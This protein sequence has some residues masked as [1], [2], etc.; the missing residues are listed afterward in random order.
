DKKVSAYPRLQAGVERTGGTQASR[1]PNGYVW[2]K[3]IPGVDKF[4][5]EGHEVVEKEVS[6]HGNGAHVY[7]PK[8]WLKE[9]VKIVRTTDSDD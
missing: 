5:I 3:S 1:F 9:T 6:S 7:V 8:E 2:A 4:S